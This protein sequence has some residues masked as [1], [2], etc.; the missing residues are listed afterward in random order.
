MFIPS[1]IS[2]IS[3][4]L[5]TPFHHFQVFFSFSFIFSPFFP[6]LPSMIYIILL[7]SLFSS[8]SFPSD[9]ISF[10]LIP[11]FLPSSHFFFIPFH[12]FPLGFIFSSL[13]NTPKFLIKSSLS[14]NNIISFPNFRGITDASKFP[15]IFNNSLLL[16][17]K[18]R[19]TD[20]KV[21]VC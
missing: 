7:I 8:P 4:S 10:P 15:E 16:Q 5:L 9:L 17:H 19:R 6:S 2:H 11:S 20:I 14:E 12:F 3:S 13:V 18:E 21:V 1:L